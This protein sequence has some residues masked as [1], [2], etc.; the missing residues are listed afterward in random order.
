MGWGN[1]GLSELLH[2]R[3]FAVGDALPNGMPKYW[4]ALDFPT[5]LNFGCEKQ[6]PRL[7]DCSS[8]PDAP[9]V[10]RL[11]DGTS[12][13]ILFLT[14]PFEALLHKDC[15]SRI[16][17]AA[18]RFDYFEM[19]RLVPG[20]GWDEIVHGLLN[21]RNISAHPLAD[22]LLDWRSIEICSVLLG[23]D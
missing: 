10:Q 5:R 18:R 7:R 21:Y 4:I 2:A 1:A 17:S 3:R 13:S 12:C 20:L 23:C 14:V 6:L 9:L 16:G 15:D 19:L 8:G 11:Q 22:G